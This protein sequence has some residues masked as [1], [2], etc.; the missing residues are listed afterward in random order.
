MDT[1]ENTNQK[2]ID[3]LFATIELMEFGIMLMRQNIRRQ[4]P[5][6]SEATINRELQRWLIEQPSNFIPQDNI[7]KAS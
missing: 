2:R 7:Q 1:R 4:L 6:A 5:S 3:N